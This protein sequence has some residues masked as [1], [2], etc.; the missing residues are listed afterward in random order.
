[1]R[2]LGI[3]SG[4]GHGLDENAVTAARA[5]RFRPALREG[6]A[7]DTAGIIHIEF[8]LAY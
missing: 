1:V 6:Q 2:V 8:E 5:I 4:L 3:R 7:V